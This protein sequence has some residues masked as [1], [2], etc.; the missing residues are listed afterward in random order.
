MAVMINGH[1]VAPT[2]SSAVAYGSTLL[3]LIV[4][5]KMAEL[6]SLLQLPLVLA[7][8]LDVIICTHFSSL[9]VGKI[10]SILVS[11]PSVKETKWDNF[12]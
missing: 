4:F 5:L 3:P 9:M 12:T 7:S 6:F 11:L 8:K 1:A 2:P 10:P